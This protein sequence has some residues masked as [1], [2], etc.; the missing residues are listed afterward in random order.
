VKRRKRAKEWFE[1]ERLWRETFPFL[2]AEWRFSET[3]QEIDKILALVSPSGKTALDLCCGPGRCSIALA[4]RGFSV[5]GV[6]RTRFFLNKARARAKA[7]RVSVE[8]VQADMRDFVR[9]KAFDLVLSTYTSFGYFMDKSED[10]RV[11]SNIFASLRGGGSFFIEMLGKEIIAKNFA[12]FHVDP[13][14]DGSMLVEQRRILNEWS[15]VHTDWTVIRNNRAQRFAFE[16][17]LYSGQELREA[18]EDVGFAD[19]KLFGNIEGG[20]YDTTAR[21][22]IAIGR[23]P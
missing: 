10:A 5:C 20:P 19:V 16:V 17:N 11:L 6:D 9:P 7:A 1:D 12:P 23:K 21:R 3:P 8:W 18:M 14:P 2:F 15:R 4:A 13:H 22:L